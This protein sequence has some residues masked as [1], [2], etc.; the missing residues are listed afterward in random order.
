MFGKYISVAN[1][2]KVSIN[3]NFIKSVLVIFLC[4]T[5]FPVNLAVDCFL[6]QWTGQR[7]DSR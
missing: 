2:C 7:G 3:L 6:E 5:P 4:R 1:Y